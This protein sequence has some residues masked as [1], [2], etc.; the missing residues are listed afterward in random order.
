MLTIIHVARQQIASNAKHGTND[1]V[2]IIN[3]NLLAE[4]KYSAHSS[5][6]CTCMALSE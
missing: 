6:E 2:L 3:G 1:P 4:F 5:L